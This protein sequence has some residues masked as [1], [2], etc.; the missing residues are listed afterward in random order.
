MPN[1]ATYISQARKVG[2]YTLDGKLVKVYDT[3][4]DCRKEFGNVSK[5]LKGLVKTCKGYIFKY[6]EK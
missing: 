6:I 4:R 5:V 2:Q 3:V 1:K